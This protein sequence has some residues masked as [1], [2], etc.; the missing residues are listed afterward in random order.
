MLLAIVVHFN[1]GKA[2][3]DR[4]PDGTQ[5]VVIE[6]ARGNV[7]SDSYCDATT[8]TYDRIVRFGGELASAAAH[9]DRK[10]LVS[11][12]QFPLRVNVSAADG[13]VKTSYVRDERSLMARFT[14]IFTASVLGQLA[15]LEPHDVFC[16]NGM[17]T[18]GNGMIWAAADRSG[19]VRMSVINR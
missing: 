18:I 8:G 9:G 5:H 4:T 13:T 19:D 11:L 17:S 16:R 7:R 2:V 3:V 15:R 12:V 10:G 14:S 1:G 6:D